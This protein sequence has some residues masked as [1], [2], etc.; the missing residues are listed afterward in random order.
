MVW[1]TISLDGRTDLCACARCGI[2]A[3]IHRSAILEPIIRPHADA[4]GDAF[5][6]MQYIARVPTAWQSMTFL[7]DECISV[8]NWPVR[9]PDLNPI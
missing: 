8:M 7:Y 1:A 6:V 2:T 3:A 4:I 5:I 9:S